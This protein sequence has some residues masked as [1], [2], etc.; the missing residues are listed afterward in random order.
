MC[1]FSGF[2][3][4]DSLP[5]DSID[6]LI[7]MGLAIQGRGPDSAGEWLD[8]EHNIGLSHR[9]LAIVDLSAAG[10]Q[11]MMSHA[12][13]FVVAFNGEIYNHLAL[14]DMLK[15]EGAGVK[16]V[17]HSDTETLLAGFEFWGVR[18]TIEKSTGMFAFSVLDTQNSE[19]ILGRDRLGEKPLYYGWQGNTFLFG[20]QLKA[21]K[22]HPDFRAEVDRD[23][24]TLLM[25]HS[26]I[27]A[28]YSIY[29]DM[30]KLLP[31]HLYYLDIKSRE[32]RTECYWSLKDVIYRSE[33]VKNSFS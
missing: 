1:G 8:P 31:G 28:P 23:S 6:V 11:P 25:R 30:N 14:R 21:L 15:N 24:L 32:S 33:L 27:P 20:S 3:S 12:E 5:G 26:N 13:R 16:W 19:L 22:E 29:R 17:G 7:K 10:H 18:E 4:K 9:R 2:L